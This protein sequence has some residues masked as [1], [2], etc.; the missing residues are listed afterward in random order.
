MK[1]LYMFLF[2]LIEI[3]W[4]RKAQKG[5]KQIFHSTSIRRLQIKQTITEEKYRGL[6]LCKGR[7]ISSQKENCRQQHQQQRRQE[8]AEITK[9][10]DKKETRRCLGL[11]DLQSSESPNHHR[12]RCKPTSQPRQE[13]LQQLKVQL[14]S[15]LSFRNSCEGR[16]VRKE[17]CVK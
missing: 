9:R 15:T 1:F 14:A 4:Q 16:G 5:P 11:Q 2:N 8:N 17:A 6:G 13:G 12:L 3:L 10:N 7:S